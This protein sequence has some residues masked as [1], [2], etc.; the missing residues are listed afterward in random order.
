METI[1]YGEQQARVEKP[2]SKQRGIVRHAFINGGAREIQSALNGLYYEISEE[3]PDLEQAQ[4][5]VELADT[6]PS[7]PSKKRLQL[8]NEARS[9]D[10]SVAGPAREAFILA[11]MPAVFSGV[12]PFLT[13]DPERNLDYFHA[14]VEGVANWIMSSNPTIDQLNSLITSHA[15][16]GAAR[17]SRGINKQA[18]NRIEDESVPNETTEE[19]AFKGIARREAVRRVREVVGL[20][21]GR[22]RE[23]LERL[24]GLRT[25]EA[26]TQADYAREINRSR[27]LI[28][29]RETK[30]LKKIKDSNRG[31]VL[32]EFWVD[33]DL[34]PVIWPFPRA[35]AGKEDFIIDLRRH[36]SKR[37][38]DREIVSANETVDAREI[39]RIQEP[40]RVVETE[41]E[42]S[43]ELDELKRTLGDIALA[44]SRV[45]AFV[46][47]E[48][49]EWYLEYAEKMK[50]EGKEITP[51]MSKTLADN[52]RMCLS[53]IAENGEDSMVHLA[54]KM[55]TIRAI[56]S[57]NVTRILF[58]DINTIGLE[59]KKI[60][61]LKVLV[62]RYA[63]GKI[64]EMKG[65]GPVRIGEINEAIKEFEKLKASS[66]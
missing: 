20:L 28:K 59:P 29:Q 11:G 3:R 64:T 56:Y 42:T 13:E 41:R 63:E 12:K 37:E 36:L 22:E 2:Y 47:K 4:I 58:W 45:G 66:Q 30:I 43:L 32:R 34:G 1:S 24:Y 15:K 55:Q 57:Y 21:S 65:L 40:R 38:K 19:Q 16:I 48:I 27:Q 51:S 53:E 62:Q 54:L 6:V 61:D 23:L 14:G 9:Q 49:L 52:L 25:G 8:L 10:E 17:F 5:Y 44:H 33:Q 60:S 39:T 26:M 31:E 18:K 46:D 7:M 35:E 50:F